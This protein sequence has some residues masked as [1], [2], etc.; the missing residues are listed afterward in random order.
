M[1]SAA[2]PLPWRCWGLAVLEGPWLCFH[3]PAHPTE[4]PSGLPGLHGI[5]LFN[6]R[7]QL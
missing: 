5:D 4:G 2:S 1:T 3:C 7:A 6:T